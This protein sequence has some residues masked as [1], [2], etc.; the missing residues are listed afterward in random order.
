MGTSDGRKSE[1]FSVLYRTVTAHR[2]WSV[3]L[4]LVLFG[5]RGPVL[6]GDIIDGTFG[7]FKI[8]AA[9]TDPSN[10]PAVTVAPN[11]SFAVSSPGYFLMNEPGSG[12]SAGYSAWSA[13]T[14]S[15]P[16]FPDSVTSGAMQQTVFT[17]PVS[18]ASV[19][20]ASVSGDLNQTSQSAAALPSD[21]T[22]AP[23]A[24]PEPASLWLLGGSLAIFV[25]WKHAVRR[26]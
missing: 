1:I 5:I 23:A 9:S 13:S 18:T 21:T 6:R 14:S 16:F 3:I 24:V 25:L 4:L 8:T 2:T 15:A 12:A 17:A 20:T 22:A 10:S 7:S 19:S 26:S 11:V